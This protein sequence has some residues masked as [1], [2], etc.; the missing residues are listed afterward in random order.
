MKKITKITTLLCALVMGGSSLIGLT[1]CN[2]G[3]AK[4][5]V[6]AIECYD[7]GYGRAW[8]DTIADDFCAEYGC[9]VDIKMA[10]SVASDV[11]TQVKSGKNMRDIYIS[12]SGLPWDEYARDGYLADLSEVYDAQVSK[13][14]GT[15][16]AVKD[17]ML[18]FVP[19][20]YSRQRL[21]GVT[22]NKPWAMPWGC[23]TLGLVVNMDMLAATKHKT[24]TDDWTAGES[25]TT[26][27]LQASV[28]NLL[29]YYSELSLS[30]DQ[31]ALG[32]S[33]QEIHHLLYPV[34]SWWAQYQGIHT[35][36]TANNVKYGT[37]Y[38]FWNAESADIWK[39]D[40]IVKALDTLQTFVVNKTNK[41]YNYKKH[42]GYLADNFKE[43]NLQDIELRFM[44]GK[45]ATMI[46]GS[47]LESEAQVFNQTGMK[48]ELIPFP[49]VD[50]AQVKADGSPITTSYNTVGECMIVPAQATNLDL[51]KKFL[52]Y[53][54]NEK[55]LL[56]FT[57]KTGTLRPFQYDPMELA[58]EHS[59]TDF[60]KSIISMNNNCD[61]MLFTYPLDAENPS[62]MATYFGPS[63][64]WQVGNTTI[65]TS[66]L[67]T[68]TAS[69]IMADVYTTN[70]SEFLVRLEE[71][72]I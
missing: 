36:N 52:A 7:G 55:Y 57:K 23:I 49:N 42:G 27:E 9:E 31:A 68:K 51:A 29:L 48:Y 15:K 43:L 61:E 13:L 35:V 32:I 39:Q 12:Q 45:Y 22:E 19:S 14:D 34:Y 60:Q 67:K 11:S 33:E 25:W 47:F 70:K 3:G 4:E 65:L 37:F 71:L 17:Y 24:T 62:A 21:Y 50:G 18:D 20:M 2:N 46:A 6:L 69:Q 59:W 5:G 63:L 26:Q 30:A 38:D 1:G 58:P 66:W 41:D 53:M 72:G 56:D 40:G 10:T 54:C 28:D 16:V 64:F 44:Q 8:L